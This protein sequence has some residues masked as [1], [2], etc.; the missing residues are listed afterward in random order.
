MSLWPHYANKEKMT[1]E[2]KFVKIKPSNRSYLPI[3]LMLRPKR[4]KKENWK[5]R[6]RT[7]IIRS[8][9][10]CA[11]Q[12]VSGGHGSKSCIVVRNILTWTTFETWFHQW[13]LSANRS[14]VKC[15]HF[16]F[17]YFAMHLHK[18]IDCLSKKNL[19]AYMNQKTLFNDTYSIY[20]PSVWTHLTTFIQYFSL[21]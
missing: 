1:Y 18:S 10:V 19:P 7:S 8:F 17:I 11:V 6:T 2:F 9:P 4:R 13:M 3:Y 16:Y 14:N 5:S 12:R 15:I 21:F 20:L